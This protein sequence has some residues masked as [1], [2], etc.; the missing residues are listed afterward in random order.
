LPKVA[1]K[2][3]SVLRTTVGC[4]LACGIL[5]APVQAQRYSFTEPVTGLDNLDVD[6]AAQD[7]AGYLWVGTENGL[8]QFDGS[9]FTKIGPSRGLNARTIQDILATPE[10]DLLVGTTEGVFVRGPN[11]NF[12]EILPPDPS[13]RFSLRIGSVF[14]RTAPGR[15]VV[16]DRSGVYELRQTGSGAWTSRNLHLFDQQVW[17]VLS[18]PAGTL[19]F[20]CGD[21]L[22]RLQADRVERM[23]AALHLPRERWLHLKVDGQ[24]HLWLRGGAH[25]EEIDLKL[26]HSTE[27]PLQGRVNETPYDSLNVDAQGRI[28]A[29]QGPAFGIWMGDH[30]RLVTQHNGL[31]RYDISTLVVDHAG[32]IWIGIVGHGLFRWVG[33]DQWEGFTAADGLSDDIIWSTERDLKGRLWIGTESGLDWMEPNSTVLHHWQAEGISSVRAISLALDP[34]GDIW[35]GSGTGGLLRIDANTKAARVWHV[36]EVYRLLMGPNG[37]LWIATNGGLFLLDTAKAGALPQLVTAPVIANPKVRFRNLC[38]DAEGRLW[39]ASDVALYRL[40]DAGWARIDTG[41]SGVIPYQIAVDRNGNLW[42]AGLFAGLD[43]MHVRGDKVVEC[44]RILRPHLLSEQVVSLQLDSRGWLWVGQDAGFTVFDGASWR[45]ITQDDGLI[46]NDTDTYAI[47]EDKDGS[48]WLGTSGGISHLLKPTSVPAVE[49]S[50]PDIQQIYFGQEQLKPGS[51]VSWSPSA[52]TVTLTALNFSEAHHIRIRYRLLGL[53]NDWVETSE[54]TLRYAR[55]APGQYTFQAETA[56]V[57]GS[58]VSP[59]LEFQFTVEP[60]WWQS[61]LFRSLMILIGLVALVLLWQWRVQLLVGQKRQLEQAVLQRTLELELEKTELLKAR[62]EMRHFAEHDGLSGLLNHR[63]IV[64]RLRGEVERSRREGTTLSIIMIDLDHF[65]RINDGHGH[66]A[67][68]AALVQLARVLQRSVRSYDW[69]GRYGGEEFLLIM[70][71]SS[72]E[73]ARQRAEQLRNAIQAMSIEHADLHLHITASFGVAAGFPTAYDTMLK[74]AD[75]AL[76]RAKHNGRNCVVALELPPPL[77]S[78]GG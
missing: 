60:R 23:G 18:D 37:R 61:W 26:L 62:D 21:D 77:D 66:P 42:A 36:P 28:L 68:D 53:E 24:G 59:V 65:K 32:S 27:R 1:R 74:L 45:S 40:D 57:T 41:L 63:I 56:E 2:L 48:M 20:G 10:G 67:G 19:W 64:D 22:C 7:S 43:R 31:S 33:Q 76:Y 69:V 71:G 75:Q 78:S 55:L 34:T 54:E 14:T 49:P 50:R 4:V 51:K 12:T 6:S 13:S 3:W 25:I 5:L 35:M 29:S 30:W 15:F 58:R 52:L 39:A 8:Y 72:F 9:H 38:Y 70:P 11:G 47:Y 73:A 16:T 17:S 46:W 44:E